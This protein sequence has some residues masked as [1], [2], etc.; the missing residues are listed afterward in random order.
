MPNVWKIY[1]S[2]IIINQLTK[3][4]T[5][6][7]N[8]TAVSPVKAASQFFNQENVKK[9]FEEVL[10]RNANAYVSSILTTINSNQLLQKASP[11]SI[12]QSAMV[13]ASL[14]LPIN[15]SLGFAW[16]V[17]YGQQAQFQ[18]GWR[19]FVQLAQ[20]TGQYLNINVITI[21]KTQFVSFDPLS[22]KLVCD[23]SKEPGAD[24]AGFAAYF[25]LLNGFTKTV[26]W[27]MERVTA[28]G[29]RYSKS[30]SNGPWKSNFEEMAQKTVLKNA[31]SKW[32][33]M[34]IEMQ[35][36]LKYDQA[37]VKESGEPDYV[38]APHTDVTNEISEEEKR[39][40]EMLAGCETW[41]DLEMLKVN[42]P[43]FPKELIAARQKEIE[44][45]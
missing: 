35:Q 29:K 3:T 31:L 11:E 44:A 6:S 37:V 14:N 17:P 26:Y 40:A 22:E 4:K 5:M 28:H 36:A 2:K 1:C 13:A 24:I 19:G 34:S 32:G 16:I 41:E 21:Y 10:G 20:R 15:Q 27:P 45:K 23:F 12:Y 42:N 8:S 18:L 33:I 9:K 43:D 7:N 30:F 38:D 39:R 25:E